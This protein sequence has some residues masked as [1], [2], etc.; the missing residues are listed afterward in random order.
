MRNKLFFILSIF[1]FFAVDAQKP[2]KSDIQKVESLIDSAYQKTTVVDMKNSAL[3]AQKALQLSKE[4]NYTKG[5]AWS[6]FY[7]GQALFELGTYKEA[8][9]YLQKGESINKT[10]KDNYLTFEIYRVRSRIFG[11]ME[12][13]DEAIDEQ[14]KGLDIIPQIPRPQSD[15]DFLTGLAYENLAVSYSKTKNQDSFYY[16]LR[17]NEELLSKQ[18]SS[19]VYLNLIT[20]YT[21]FGAYYTDENQFDKAE[22]YFV[23]SKN[24]SEKHNYPYI[25]FTYQVWG[26][27]ELARKNPKSALHYFEKSLDILNKTDFRNEIPDVYNKIALAY[28]DLGNHESAKDFKFKA[29]KLQDE[30][31]KEKIQAS[32]SALDEILNSKIAKENKKSS[33]HN[34]ILLG[35][36]S[37]MVMLL[38]VLFIKYY[39]AR[40]VKN[41]RK[42]LIETKEKELENREKEIVELHQKVNESFEEVA[43]LAKTNSPEFFTRFCEVYPEVVSKIRA[44]NPELRISELTLCAYIFLGLN[45]KDIVNFTF[46]SINTVK[47]RKYHLRKKLNIPEEI[48]TDMWFKNLTV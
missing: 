15:K 45:T 47:S 2:T 16:Y 7:I 18:D 20:L 26:D 30:L 21:M 44:I 17:K 5:E 8:L 1:L 46:T 32:S 48:S 23:K 4:T 36:I 37:M 25:S 3:F 29:L 19:A 6:N 13:L 42:Q 28:E 27:M 35:I 43:N 31:N 39:R 9:H 41:Y 40:K 24:I 14:K 10:L 22:S 33:K 11:S 34:L 38:S 12:L